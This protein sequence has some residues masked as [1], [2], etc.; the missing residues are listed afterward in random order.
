MAFAT[1]PRHCGPLAA[2][3]ANLRLLGRVVGVLL[4]LTAVALP[5]PTDVPAGR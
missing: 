1:L 3:T 4:P 2:A 5:W